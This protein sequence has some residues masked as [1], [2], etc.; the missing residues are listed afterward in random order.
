M[1][2]SRTAARRALHVSSNGRFVA[3]TSVAS[4]LVAN[5]EHGLGRGVR[6]GPPDGQVTAG[7][8]PGRR[9]PVHAREPVG[10]GDLG[11]RAG[12]RL[13]V[14]AGGAAVAR[15]PRRS[16]RP[17]LGPDTGQREVVSRNVKGGPRAARA[18]RPSRRDGRYV[19]YTSTVRLDPA[20]TTT[21]P[22]TCSA[23]TAGPRRP[24]SS[25]RRL[26]RW[27]DLGRRNSPSI[28]GDGNLVAFVVR[29]RR[30]RA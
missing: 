12:R 22:T 4:N 28:S 6:P 10:A 18:S 16:V 5:D 20:T 9:R 3:F 23:S 29:R 2:V 1:A 30:L 8:A 11:R 24:S 21:T 26:P 15:R 17:R 27:H 7:A 13:H 14:P 19:A 25:P